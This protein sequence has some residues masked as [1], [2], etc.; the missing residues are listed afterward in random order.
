[1]IVKDMIIYKVLMPTLCTILF[2]RMYKTQCIDSNKLILY[3]RI[4]REWIKYHE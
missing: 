2:L 4:T 3:N 1:M